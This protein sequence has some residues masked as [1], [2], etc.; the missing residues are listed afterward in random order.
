MVG[1]MDESM[2]RPAFSA[3]FK[4]WF[5]LFDLRVFLKA[6]GGAEN[7]KSKFKAPISLPEKLVQI[8]LLV[9]FRKQVYLN[10]LAMFLAK[11]CQLV[12]VKD[13]GS[14]Y[15]FWHPTDILLSIRLET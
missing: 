10:K 1:I 13:S 5:R 2:C 12:Y 8:E 4:P 15:S 14:P 9:K 6:T 7:L 3:L 11:V